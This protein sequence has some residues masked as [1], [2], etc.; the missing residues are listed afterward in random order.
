MRCTV[1]A[2]KLA[3]PLY[4]NTPSHLAP[5]ALL[6]LWRLVGAYGLDHCD[7][8]LDVSAGDPLA[9]SRVHQGPLSGAAAEALGERFEHSH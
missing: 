7:L 4:L 8:A 9:K 2:R 5:R 6:R 1:S 3:L